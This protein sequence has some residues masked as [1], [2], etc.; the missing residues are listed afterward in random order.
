MANVRIPDL[1]TITPTDLSVLDLFLI[2]DVSVQQ[3]KKLTVQDLNTYIKT[4]GG[5]YTGSFFGTSSVSNTSIS[6]SYSATSSFVKNATSASIALQTLS[7]SY[8]V[9]SSCTLTA[10]YA[11]ISAIQMTYSSAYA[12]YANTASNLL[13]VAGSPNGTSS[14]S[15]SASISKLSINSN[16]SSLSNT[17]SYALIANTVIGGGVINGGSY[18]ISS[19][20]A[21]SS[22]SSS[23]TQTASYLYWNGTSNGTASYALTSKSPAGV[24]IDYGTFTSTNQSSTMSIVDT[25]TVAPTI[26]TPMLSTIE[27]VGTVILPITNSSITNGNV[28]L[29][30]L[31]RWSGVI[32]TLDSTPIYALLNCS[33][34]LKVPF[35]LVGDTSMS[36]SI[37]LYITTSG[38]NIDITRTP[39]FKVSSF[40]DNIYVSVPESIIFATSPSTILMDY[41]SSLSPGSVQNGSASVIVSVGI[42]NITDIHVSGSVINSMKYIW[43]LPNLKHF[44]CGNSSN[45]VNI[46]G[47]PLSM[48]TMSCYSCNLSS[49][50]PLTYTSTSILLCQNNSLTSIPSLPS[51]MSYINCS[52]NPLTSLPSTLPYGLTVLYADASRITSLPLSFPSSLL[53]MSVSSTNISTWYT[54]FPSS[55]TYLNCS[56]TPL[57]NLPTLSSGLLYVNVSSCNMTPT[58]IDN[59]CTTLI[60]NGLNNGN[61]FINYNNGYLPST[62]AK[63]TTLQSR[64]WTVIY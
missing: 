40:S 8:A 27:A 63:I 32:Q 22:I 46:G 42:N 28:T 4:Y 37:Q 29:C 18:N 39:K 60:S 12:T 21:S 31:D 3:S 30:T 55:L 49:I 50:A 17:A 54:P 1:V 45:L 35:T 26:G 59:I 7:A 24:R 16:T 44:D 33:G 2:S 11:L 6:T 5:F 61:L 14:Y 20:F 23:T 62:A 43:T 64:G 34:T 19:S 58:A 52:G 56:T 10:S 13:Y 57:T 15:I 48:V 41:S 36:G 53:T 47:M 38:V 9:S 51:T 25:L